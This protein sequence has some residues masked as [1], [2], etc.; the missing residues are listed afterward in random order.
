MKG[1]LLVVGL[2]VVAVVVFWFLKVESVKGEGGA[3]ETSR[4]GMAGG[5]SRLKLV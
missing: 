3:G 4:V 1:W 5:E 2:F